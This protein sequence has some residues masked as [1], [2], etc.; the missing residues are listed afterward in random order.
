MEN[1]KQQQKQIDFLG[2]IIFC[3]VGVKLEYKSRMKRTQNM[4]RAEMMGKP[5]EPVR[6]EEC[7]KWPLEVYGEIV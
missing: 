4:K 1:S 6:V 7:S 5:K 3:L 2:Q